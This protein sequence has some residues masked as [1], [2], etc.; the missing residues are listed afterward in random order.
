MNLGLLT[1]N[2]AYS[3]ERFQ[4]LKTLDAK[5]RHAAVVSDLNAL[6][7]LPNPKVKSLR[8]FEDRHGDGGQ[9]VFY[10]PFSEDLAR[11]VCPKI[12]ATRKEDLQSRSMPLK[13]PRILR[14]PT[15]DPRWPFAVVMAGLEVTGMV[16]TG[17]DFPSKEIIESDD[18]D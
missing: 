5:A 12:V 8:L 17:G 7:R 6:G 4:V 2:V 14:P 15:V 18:E 9:V 13:R 16:V 3:L 10:W 11:N 1:V